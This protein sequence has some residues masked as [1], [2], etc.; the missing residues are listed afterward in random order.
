MMIGVFERNSPNETIVII[1]IIKRIIII[2]IAIINA[3]YTGRAKQKKFVPKRS[4]Y[5]ASLC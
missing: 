3:Q 4:D 5:A 1:I 2:M